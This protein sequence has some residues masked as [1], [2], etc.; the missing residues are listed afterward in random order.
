MTLADAVPSESFLEYAF[1]RWVLAPAAAPDVAARVRAQEPVLVNGHSYRL[2]YQLRGDKVTVALELDG[3]A[4]HSGRSAF[5]YD[6]LRQ[7]DI[8]ATGPLI[9][10]F[11]YD[12]IRTDTAR[13]IAQLQAVMARD[14]ALARLV[15]SNPSVERPEMD[16]DPMTALS[17]SPRVMVTAAADGYFPACAMRS[18]CERCANA[19][20]RHSR[21]LRTTTARAAG[22]PHA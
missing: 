20:N 18:T 7:N 3:F 9:V 17:P 10:R 21:R 22:R 15:I 2:D 4:A 8:A 13:C 19:R 11:S 16:P 14:P 6:R 1:L 5:T 12:A